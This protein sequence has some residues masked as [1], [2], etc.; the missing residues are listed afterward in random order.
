MFPP[1]G[2]AQAG[3]WLMW[4]RLSS[5]NLLPSSPTEAV[6]ATSTP[7]EKGGGKGKRAAAKEA[8]VLVEALAMVRQEASMGVAGAVESLAIVKVSAPALDAQNGQ[9]DAEK[10]GTSKGG[11]KGLK[12]SGKG[13]KGKG[14]HEVGWSA[15]FYAQAGWDGYSDCDTAGTWAGVSELAGEQARAASSPDRTASIRHVGVRREISWCTCSLSQSA[16]KTFLGLLVPK[17]SRPVHIARSPLVA[18]W[19]SRTKQRKTHWTKFADTDVNEDGAE[20]QKERTLG[21]PQPLWKPSQGTTLPAEA[22]S[23]KHGRRTPIQVHESS[24]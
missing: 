18:K 9:R 17:C 15:D 8:M 4:S 19:R 11:S 16:H 22:R 13:G 3:T 7:L 5:G 21:V 23:R 6:L 24:G 2:R 1:A 12:G 14:L 10:G 20:T